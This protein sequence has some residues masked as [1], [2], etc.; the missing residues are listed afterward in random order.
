MKTQIKHGRAVT[1]ILIREHIP[2][3][4][5]CLG[6]YQFGVRKSIQPVKLSDEV[7]VWLYVWSKVQI[8]CI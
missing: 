2:N 3:A 1:A 4:I 8:V 5:L 7:L 6:H